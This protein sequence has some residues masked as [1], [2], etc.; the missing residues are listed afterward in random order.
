VRVLV[1]DDDT[2]V[3]MML[4]I[5]SP[6]IEVLEASRAS[7]GY[8]LATRDRPDAIVVDRRLP[9]G[10]GIE[11]VRRLRTNRATQQTPIV[12]ITA[13]HDPAWDET[14]RRAGADVYL[15]KPVTAPELIAHLRRRLAIEPAQRRALR[16]GET[17]PDDVGADDATPERRRWWQ[18]RPTD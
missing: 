4:S 18:R 8:E 9:D 12:L 5:E 17:A 1:V 16:R 2:F 13:G 6:D 7:E 10:D 14:V 11:L 15:P 3:R